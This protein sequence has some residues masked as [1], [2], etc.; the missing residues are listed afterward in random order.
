[1]KM[2]RF[3]SI[4]A[5][6]NNL[7]YMKLKIIKSFLL[8]LSTP[9]AAATVHR[10]HW[11]RPESSYTAEFPGMRMPLLTLLC[12]VIL[13]LILMYSAITMIIIMAKDILAANMDVAANI[14]VD[15]TNNWHSQAQ[16]IL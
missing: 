6:Q 9:M 7:K 2:A 11:H 3:F 15:I 10:W 1:M 13:R 5:T 14:I 4:L 16:Y 12:L 8:K